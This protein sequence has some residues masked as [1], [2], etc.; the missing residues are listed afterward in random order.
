M[1]IRNQTI[2]ALLRVEAVFTFCNSGKHCRKSPGMYLVT[3]ISMCLHSA[4]N[5]LF[6]RQRGGEM[7]EIRGGTKCKET[8]SNWNLTIHFIQRF[9]LKLIIQILIHTPVFYPPQLTNTPSPYSLSNPKYHL[10]I[11]SQIVAPII[12]P[13]NSH[14]KC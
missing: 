2:W 8:A 1:F 13:Q 14:Q 3:G 7:G 11:D 9:F 10:R 12:L 5:L 4:V 6:S